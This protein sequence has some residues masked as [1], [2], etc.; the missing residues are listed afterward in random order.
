MSKYYSPP[1]RL[2]PKYKFGDQVV[3]KDDFYGTINGT[4][5]NVAE[6]ETGV[7]WWKSYRLIYQVSAETTEMFLTIYV[8]EDTL[9]PVVKLKP[10]K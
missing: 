6:Q 1:V 5:D 10:V 7:L 2:K 4:V 9:R 3:V 8:S